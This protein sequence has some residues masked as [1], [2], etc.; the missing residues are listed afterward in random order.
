MALTNS[1][2]CPG[3][4]GFDRDLHVAILAPATGLPDVPSFGFRCFANRLFER[5]LRF[6]DVCA[7]AEFPL[8]PVDDDFEMQLTHPGNDRLPGILIGMDPERGILLSQFSQ[9]HP[10]F[11]L[12][13]FRLGLDGNGDDRLREIHGLREE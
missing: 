9:R 7:D 12:V 4:G 2:T 3:V 8:H 6:T 13:G 10:H 1:R 11:F 5:N